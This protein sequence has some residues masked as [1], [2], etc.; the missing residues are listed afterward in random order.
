[1]GR[2]AEPA[3]RFGALE[4]R[5]ASPQ[6]VRGEAYQLAG[7]VGAPVKALDNPAADA[8]GK[9]TPHVTFLPVNAADCDEFAGGGRRA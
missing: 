9:P 1:M 3:R 8:C 5:V 6:Q 2:N 7:A 4:R